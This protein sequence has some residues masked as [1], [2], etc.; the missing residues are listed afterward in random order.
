MNTYDEA[1]ENQFSTG[2]IVVTPD[3]EGLVEKV[4]PGKKVVVVKLR[5]AGCIR[6]F[7]LEEV[8]RV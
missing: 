1:R 4:H 3:G 5:E 2:E 7:P 8:D 6:E